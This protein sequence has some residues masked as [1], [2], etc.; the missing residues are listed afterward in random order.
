MATV[1]N[2]AE[3]TTAFGAEGLRVLVE[4]SKGVYGRWAMVFPASVPKTEAQLRAK[5]AADLVESGTWSRND[6]RSWA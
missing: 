3:I 6:A 4:T 1:I 2:T 5:R